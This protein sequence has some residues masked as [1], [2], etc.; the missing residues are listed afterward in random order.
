MTICTRSRRR[1][2]GLDQ[3]YRNEERI[4]RE[5]EDAE[6]KEEKRRAKEAKRKAQDEEEDRRRKEKE[7]AR[8]SQ[9]KPKRKPFNY[10]QVRALSTSETRY[11]SET[12]SMICSQEKPQ[13]LT[14]IANASAA[15]SNLVNAITVRYPAMN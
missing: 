6:R 11:R 8:A 15:S 4:R 13:I 14:A 12:H 2:W 5:K 7:K 9:G 1:V 3:G 10:E